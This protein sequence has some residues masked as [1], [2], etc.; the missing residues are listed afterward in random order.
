M[1]DKLTSADIFKVKGIIE[2]H[3]H[4]YKLSES[5]LINSLRINTSLKNEINIAETSLELAVLYEEIDN[6]NSRKSYLESA[7]KHYKQIQVSQKVKEIEIML[8][9]EVA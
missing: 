4:N 2:R 9:L 5:Y 7:L 3:L 8:G 1:D 6:S